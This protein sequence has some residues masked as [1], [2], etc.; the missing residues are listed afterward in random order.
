MKDAFGGIVNIVLVATNII[1][2]ALDDIRA[3]GVEVTADEMDNEQ[4]FAMIVNIRK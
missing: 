2:K 4:V 3:L 1:K